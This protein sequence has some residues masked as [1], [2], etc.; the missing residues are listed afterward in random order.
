MVY[1]PLTRRRFHVACLLCASVTRSNDEKRKEHST[2]QHIRRT[3]AR[4][5]ASH[6]FFS[7][8]PTLS[9]DP[10][11][12]LG[13]L[14]LPFLCL[15]YFPSF[16]KFLFCFEF[17]RQRCGSKRATRTNFLKFFVRSSVYRCNIPCIVSTTYTPS[18]FESI[19]FFALPISVSAPPSSS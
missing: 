17:A 15:L 13:R 12:Y 2:Q 19:R 4:A 10:S 8:R 7:T 9:H 14:S 16:N 11:S 3:A 5:A 1:L 18:Q 6:F